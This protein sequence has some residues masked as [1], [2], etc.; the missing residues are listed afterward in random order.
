MRRFWKSQ[1]AY[2]GDKISQGA[3]LPPFFENLLPEGALLELVRS[4]FGAGAFDIFDVLRR[5]GEDLPG[6]VV[7]L[8]KTGAPPPRLRRK[9]S[10]AAL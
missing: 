3:I 10:A 9:R 6:A 1:N 5:L 7:A 2:P 8:Q 4:E